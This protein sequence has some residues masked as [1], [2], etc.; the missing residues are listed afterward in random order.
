MRTLIN[1]PKANK[2]EITVYD[3]NLYCAQIA[4]TMDASVLLYMIL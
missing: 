3:N 2:N 4:N 1:N